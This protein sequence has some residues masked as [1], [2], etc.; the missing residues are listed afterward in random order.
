MI[1]PDFGEKCLYILF[2]A[3]V[4]P[5]AISVAVLC[6]PGFAFATGAGIYDQLVSIPYNPPGKS[7][8]SDPTLSGGKFLVAARSIRDPRFKETVILLVRYDSDGAIGLIINLP[9]GVSL[10]SAL[11]E[12]KELRKRSDKIFIGGP[13]S[14]NQLFLLIKTDKP[15]EGSFHIFRHTYLNS[16]MTALRQ[17]AGDKKKGNRFRI[18]AGYAG[19]A[20]GQLER[21]V[22]M[23]SWHVVE[24]D[25][26]LIFEKDLSD[27]W[28]RL[29]V[30]RSG[31]MVRL[32]PGGEGPPADLLSA[33]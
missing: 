5:V 30:G 15:P 11:P 19:W 9:T 10:S 27:L 4:V 21:E 25:E 28:Q 8:R 29:N 6:R 31:I 3:V 32:L 2:A 16:S 24:A 20:P 17:V 22:A 23:G 1:K 12:I 33:E 13:V 26:K 7:F 18:F 14:G